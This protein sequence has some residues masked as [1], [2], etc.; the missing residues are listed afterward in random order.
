MTDGNGML[1]LADA[2]ARRSLAEPLA[3]TPHTAVADPYR[4][5]AELARRE[6]RVVVLT[7]PQPEF[8]G[9][10]RAA[11]RLAPEAKLLAVSGPAGE[12]QANPLVGAAL[13]DYFIEPLEADDVEAI[14]Q[15][16]GIDGEAA[17]RTAPAEAA[18]PARRL[19]ELIDASRD[20]DEM[21]NHL[22]RVVAALVGCPV[23]W[24]PPAG[25]PAGAEPLL[26]TGGENPRALVPVGTPRLGAMAKAYLAIAQECLPSLLSAARRAQ[27]LR[28]LSITDHLTGAFNRRYFYEATERILERAEGEN[29]RVTLLLYDID[30]FKRYN[31]TYGHAAGD[32]ILRDTARMMKQIT[33][34]QDIVARIG[35]DEFAVLF[36]DADKPRSP[37]SRPPETAFALADRFRQAVHKHAFGSL[38]PEAVGTLTISGGLA[39]YPAD[40]TT[41]RGLLSQADAALR[42]VKETGKNAIRIVGPGNSD[43]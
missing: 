18:E 11:R 30:D 27:G 28:Q 7:G 42:Q 14:R 21:D 6:W 20:L 31:D 22:V 23:T 17:V 15:A 36:W 13:D 41:V 9:L 5:L 39:S 37:N 19:A 26:T 8:A 4:A 43:R 33:R 34:A 12:A 29:F 25:L 32:D 38:G 1:V 35:G 40:G 10:C 2:E 3:G 16:A 24:A